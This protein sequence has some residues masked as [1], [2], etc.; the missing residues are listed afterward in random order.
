MVIGQ[1]WP[2]VG[3]AEVQCGRLAAELT[4]QGYD[5][6]VVTSRHNRSVS[7]NEIIDGFRVVRCLVIPIPRLRNL[8]FLLSLGWTLWRFRHKYDVIHAHQALRPASV[9]AVMGKL[10]GKPVVIKVSSGGKGSDIARMEKRG[11]HDWFGFLDPLLWRPIRWCDRI[12][13]IS[14]EIKRELLQA[15]FA[16]E[17]VVEI[18]NGVPLIP[19]HRRPSDTDIA[20]DP[21]K[22]ICIAGLRAVKGVDLLLEAAH[23]VSDIQVDVIGDGPELERLIKLRY[24][25]GLDDVVTFH[26]FQEETNKFLRRAQIAVFPSHAEGMSNALLEA[27]TQGIACVATAVGGN[28]DMIKD[29]VNGLLV[30]PEDPH[31]LAQAIHRLAEDLDLRTRLGIEARQTTLKRYGIARVAEQYGALYSHLGEQCMSASAR[32]G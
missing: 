17:Q 8:S 18:P 32:D 6:T 22:V 5:V 10:L 15:G 30:P 27:M 20:S 13:A 11:T 2:I 26:G 7:K 23:G 9:A 16:T 12:V 3:G 29:G 21:I 19:S 4:R 28:L 25:L 14:S 24:K 1:F 31:A